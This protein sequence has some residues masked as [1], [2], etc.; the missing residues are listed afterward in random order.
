M[1]R[2]LIVA[3][4]II[5]CLTVGFGAVNSQAETLS[6]SCGTDV[7][8]ILDTETCLLT[9]SGT[10]EMINYSYSASRAPWYSYNA[11]IKSIVIE[12]GVTS[13]GRYAFDNCSSLTSV[14]IPNSVE[15]IGSGSF[16]GC[17][18]LTSVIVPDS[19]TS[20]DLGAFADCSNLEEITIPFVGSK[21]GKSGTYDSVLGYIFGYEASYS[22]GYTL[23]YYKSDSYYYYKIPSALK[24]VTVTDETVVPYGAFYQSGN[25]KEIMLSG[26]VASIEEYAFYNC[27]S[28]E[29]IVVPESVTAIGKNAFDACTGLIYALHEGKKA[30]VSIASNNTPLTQV[31]SYGKGSCG[32]GATYSFDITAGV[33]TISGTGAMVNYSSED[34]A[35]WYKSGEYITDIVVEN[36][37][38]S[39]GSYAFYDLSYLKNI[40]ISKSVIDI[41]QYA[42]SGCDKLKY[43][44]YEGSE[45]EWEKMYISRSGNDSLIYYALMVYDSGKDANEF[46]DGEGRTPRIGYTTIIF[47]P[48][49]AVKGDIIAVLATKDGVSKAYVKIYSGSG[50][51]PFEIEDGFNTVKILIWDSCET[52]QPLMEY[53]I[54]E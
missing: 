47:T 52:I 35:P 40:T 14:T 34:T 33:L 24:K 12:D 32:G 5:V 26:S 3:F 6:G 18:A 9:I 41:E 2:N 11:D 43:V 25:I 23:Q 54:I 8:Y 31:V 38:T 51:V 45:D 39:I 53:A 4:I 37:V 7:G 46:P 49:D 42:F 13:I 36:S 19:V 1:R 50:T 44:Y 28:L 10:G 15:S 30:D 16:R 21:R 20:I 22:S 17:G 27:R 29:K 48:I